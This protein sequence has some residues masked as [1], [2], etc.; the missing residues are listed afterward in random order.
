M[1]ILNFL[2]KK[3]RLN[4][5]DSNLD[6]WT[7]AQIKLENHFKRDNIVSDTK[8]PYFL[9]LL[10]TSVH[11][12]NAF[13]SC[14]LLSLLN[15]RSNNDNDIFFENIISIA[16]FHNDL[17]VTKVKQF[18]FKEE[19]NRH[20]NKLFLEPELQIYAI[21]KELSCLTD[22]LLINQEIRKLSDQEYKEAK[23]IYS[24]YFYLLELIYDFIFDDYNHRGVFLDFKYDKMQYE[25]SKL[26][27]S[28]F[29]GKLDELLNDVESKDDRTIE[30][31]FR[32]HSNTLLIDLLESYASCSNNGYKSLRR[33]YAEFVNWY[34]KARRK[35]L[36][37]FGIEPLTWH[38]IGLIWKAE[39]YLQDAEEYLDKE[40]AKRDLI[41]F[42]N[43]LV[44][45]I[46]ESLLIYDYAYEKGTIKYE[47]IYDAEIEFIRNLFYYDIDTLPPNICS[48]LI[49]RRWD[50]VLNKFKSLNKFLPTNYY[51]AVPIKKIKPMGFEDTINTYLPQ[52]LSKEYP[53][54]VELLIEML[55]KDNLE[56]LFASFVEN[57]KTHSLEFYDNIVGVQSSGVF[58]SHILKLYMNKM[59]KPVWH[60]QLYPYV[61]IEPRHTH[62]NLPRYDNELCDIKSNNNLRILIIDESIKTGFSLSALESYIEH[63]MFHIKEKESHVH[64]LID[65][66]K[67][68][69]LPDLKSKLYSCLVEQEGRFFLTTSVSKAKSMYWPNPI[70]D[71]MLEDAINALKEGERLNLS[72]LIADTRFVLGLCR[73]FAEDIERV[74]KNN[75]NK[76][77]RVL[78]FSPSNEGRILMFMT[79]FLLKMDDIDV[80]L[81][82]QSWKEWREKNNLKVSI[83]LSEN[84]GFTL[85][86]E[87]SYALDIPLVLESE[88]V[89]SDYDD[90]AIKGKVNL[91][92][93]FFDKCLKA[94]PI[95]KVTLV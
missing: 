6:L 25:S 29:L 66:K 80:G 88:S 18:F 33:R 38:L 3:K 72:Y 50:D 5:C 22:T 43:S 62:P 44:N 19:P 82:K 31:M 51:C 45:L 48:L 26:V 30:T 83:D 74:I 23:R 81:T 14:L 1:S 28:T 10:G 20:L 37:N 13:N 71:N 4:P 21:G 47:L 67:Y 35:R 76:T 57:I 42:V 65:F 89:T 59:D 93:N 78:L 9:L 73:K 40:S 63:S 85:A 16:N 68:P 46:R 32:I 70:T 8:D 77:K 24:K 79:A 95:E 91:A 52:L 39:G 12:I 7:N 61:A 15:R 17:I 69:K 90:V 49:N 2:K 54:K 56:Y 27:I 36:D 41:K 53:L 64:A 84:T 86:K 94:W 55:D 60:F 11:R 87:L 92:K 75:K 34:D 58:L